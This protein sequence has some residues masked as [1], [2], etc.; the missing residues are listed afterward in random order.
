MADVMS[1]EMTLTAILEMT[2][3]ERMES[4]KFVRAQAMSQRLTAVGTKG[5]LNDCCPGSRLWSRFLILPIIAL[6]FVALFTVFNESSLMLSIDTGLSSHS[7]FL[8]IGLTITLQLKRVQLAPQCHKAFNTSPPTC[9]FNIRCSIVLN[10]KSN[11][12][13]L[14]LYPGSSR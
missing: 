3:V 2:K 7:Y 14:T 10:E 5:L 9:F 11:Y 4:Q 12:K 6:Y 8:G 1:S 13:I